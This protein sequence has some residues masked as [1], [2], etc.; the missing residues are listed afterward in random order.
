MRSDPSGS[1]LMMTRGKLARIDL[2]SGKITEE[3]AD[4]KLYSKFLGGKGYAAYL[5][6]KELLWK[7]DPLSPQNKLIFMTGP[8]TGTRAPTGNRFCVC[9]KSPLTGTWL[10][11]HCGGFWGPE[12]RFAGYE[13]LIF[14]GRASN[15]VYVYIEDDEIRVLDADWL[16]GADTFSTERLLKHKHRGKREPMVAEVG[17]AGERKQLLSCIVSEGRAA[18]RGG[19][20]AVMGS[21]NLK[22]IAVKGTRFKPEDLVHNLDAFNKVVKRCYKKI[23]DEKKTS[24]RLRGSLPIYGTA[25]IIDLVNEAG[26]WPTRNF[27]AGS[28]EKSSS[29][30]GPAF[31]DDLWS[32]RSSPGTKPCYNCPILCAHVA[33][34]KDGV[35]AGTVDEGPEY[36]TIWAF[37]PQCGIEDREAIARADYLCDYYGLDTISIGNT[38]GFL[39]ECYERGLMTQDD[40]NG[41]HLRFGNVSAM[42]KV[43]EMAGTGSGKIGRLAAEGVA[44]AAQTI[45][46]G[47][48]TFAIHVKSLEVP[49]YDPRS[50]QGMGLCYATSDRGACHLHAWTAGEELLGWDGRDPRATKGKAEWVKDMVETGNAAWDSSGLCRFSGFALSDKDVR[51]LI[52]AATGFNYETVE[53]LKKVGE[54]INNLTRAFNLREGLSMSAD[55]LPRRLLEEPMPTGPFKG[56][57]AKLTEMLQDYYKVCGWDNHG[58]PTA[59]KLRQLGLDFVLTR[60]RAKKKRRRKKIRKKRVSKKKTDR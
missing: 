47:S 9:T 6:F 52:V 7:V 43:V 2:S 31:A 10:D 25:N 22:A 45:G 12:L 37:G 57:V 17:P 34:V 19:A 56:Q 53:D 11:T 38:I 5:L 50:A 23:S 30:N 49:A 28:F 39:M 15:P 51:K 60:L 32:P 33:I 14:E 29:I 44:R 13:G 26:G 1:E 20:G 42:I 46:Q 18:G 54:R 21:K 27:Q 41:L 40:T 58:V 36:E 48:E 3:R 35:W 55:T 4:R 8:L 59:A 16:W 24:P